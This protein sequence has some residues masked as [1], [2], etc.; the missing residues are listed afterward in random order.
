[1][2]RIAAV[3]NYLGGKKLEYY[4][5]GYR[6]KCEV[7][8]EQQGNSLVFIDNIDF[9]ISAASDPPITIEIRWRFEIKM[10]G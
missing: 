3:I 4:Q 7:T 9:S 5:K 10:L 8:S 2:N 1:M 6:Q